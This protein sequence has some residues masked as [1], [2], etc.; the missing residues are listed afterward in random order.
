MPTVEL[1]LR[2]SPSRVV[3]W[4]SHHVSNA[5]NPTKNPLPTADL[6]QVLDSCQGESF[7]P[8][9]EAPHMWAGGGVT[10]PLAGSQAC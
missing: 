5:A 10:S 8:L 9:T 3:V 1:S 4:P 6:Q 2:S 7:H